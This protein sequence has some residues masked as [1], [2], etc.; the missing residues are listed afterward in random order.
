MAT[1][2]Y[3]QVYRAGWEASQRG[4]KR[5]GR[6]GQGKGAPVLGA[7]RQKGKTAKDAAN[8]QARAA[9]APPGE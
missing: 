8:E 3:L 7:S 2:E 6:P 1:S 5:P 4:G 9:P